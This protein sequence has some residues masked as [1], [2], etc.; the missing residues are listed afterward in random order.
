MALEKFRA[1]ALPN[2][3]EDI[4]RPTQEYLR[5]MIRALGLYFNK[6]DSL[7]PNQA[8]SYRANSFLASSDDSGALGASGTAFSDLFLATGGVI[9]WNAADVT[10]TH[11]ANTLT[12][13]GASSGY[14]FDSDLFLATG[15]VINWNAGDVTITHAANTLTFAGASTGYSFD[16]AVTATAFYGGTVLNVLSYGAVGDGST[17]DL[18]A[19]NSAIAAANSTGHPIYFPSGT[20]KVSAATDEITANGVI[21][22]GE[23]RNSTIIANAAATGNTFYLTGQ[24]SGVR[25]MSFVP[26]VFRTGDY[27]V[28]ISGGFQNF[29][30]NVYAN[31]A[32][33]GFGIVSTASALLTNISLR[34]LTGDVG[35]YYGGTSS[36]SS[37][38]L[39]CSKIV[40]DNPYVNGVTASNVTGAFAGTTAYSLSDLFTANGWVF[41]V[42][43]AGTSAASA[44]AAPTTTAWYTTSVTNGTIEVRAIHK[45]GATWIVQDNY[46]NSLSV[47]QAAL[48]NLDSGFRMDDTAATGTSYPSWAYFFDL[49]VDHSYALCCDLKHGRGFHTTAS[50]VGSCLNGNGISFNTSFIGEAI[51]QGTRVLGNAEHGILISAGTEIKI[52]DNFVCNN[53][54]K[55]T[56]TYHGVSVAA[57]VNRFTI[58]NNTVGRLVPETSSGQSWGILVNTGASDY[59]IIQGN[60]GES[61]TG[62]VQGTLSDNGTGSNKSVTGNV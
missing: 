34:Y 52:S 10:I 19:I 4:P 56:D 45:I 61:T 26:S 44:P 54:T 43:S 51:V 42:T 39:Y 18:T 24:F 62:N 58:T 25:D 30:D 57:D 17:D 47:S 2:P 6:L 59:Y 23:G 28:L 46:S 21:L 50:W 40:A 16:A 22:Y 33:R 31:F 13:A 35:I 48:L 55:T 37:Y 7:T 15:G 49:E 14:H 60:L 41:Q 53:G 3:T 38:G 29:L 1:P 5:Q 11:A 9:N 12:F 20:Y 32:Y 36:V 8:D 27:E